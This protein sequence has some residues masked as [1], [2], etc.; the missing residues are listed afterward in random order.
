M[1]QATATRDSVETIARFLVEKCRQQDFK[2]VTERYYADDIVS[3]EAMAMPGQPAELRGLEAV[4]QKQ[5]EWDANHEIHS[6]DVSEP[7]ISASEFA[8]RMTIDVTSKPMGNQ[9]MQMEEICVYSI[10]N[11]KIAREQFFYGGCEQ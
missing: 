5:Q 11:G 1:S 4:V 2:A 6:I 7:I 9:R 10:K 8:V 3:I